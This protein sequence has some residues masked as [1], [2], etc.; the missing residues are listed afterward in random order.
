[1]KWQR[2]S[3]VVPGRHLHTDIRASE[4]CTNH[5]NDLDFSALTGIKHNLKQSG[6]GESRLHRISK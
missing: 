4:L 3:T 1:M 5:R 6:F 2:G